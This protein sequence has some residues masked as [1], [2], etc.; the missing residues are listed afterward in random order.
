MNQAEVSQRQEQVTV[1]ITAANSPI[2]QQEAVAVGRLMAPL[3]LDDPFRKVAKTVLA[4]GILPAESVEPLLS[5]LTTFRP[6]RWRTQQLAAWM[7]QYAQGETEAQSSICTRLRE[8]VAQWPMRSTRRRMLCAAGWALVLSG[9]FTLSS[10]GLYPVSGGF[11]S[12]LP[13]MFVIGCIF[14]AAVL[15]VMA[16]ADHHKMTRMREQALFA[17]GRLASVDSLEVVAEA[18]LEGSA[19][20]RRMLYGKMPCDRSQT[21][22]AYAALTLMKILP[23]VQKSDYGRLA[24]STVPNLCSIL[25]VAAKAEDVANKALVLR[26]LRALN[27]IGDVRAIPAVEPLAK[28]SASEVIRQAA[29]RTLGILQERHRQETAPQTLLRASETKGSTPDTL[30]RAAVAVSE[31]TNAEELLRAEE[32][33][34]RA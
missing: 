3:H 30:L 13:F 28:G 18:C 32:G 14:W 23:C 1:D 33:M 25:P 6:N 10:M 21:I 15:P 11:V 29:T 8:I 22:R 12:A 24:A 17:L 20:W 4:T 9:G 5:H 27:H 19:L 26:I 2:T 34:N 16:I 7:L 31:Q